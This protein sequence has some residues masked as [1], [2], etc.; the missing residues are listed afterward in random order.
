MYR[1]CKRIFDLLSSAL[2]LPLL[3]PLL[4]LTALAAALGGL[5]P[6]LF[7][8][9]RTG[10]RGQPFQLLKFR[11]MNQRRTAS[12]QLLP[13]EQRLTKLGKMLRATSLDELPQ[14]WNVLRGE[15]SLVGPR[16]FIH[17]YWPLYSAEQKRRFAVRPGLTGWAQVNGRNALSWEQK[18]AFDVWYVDN[19]SFGLDLRILVCTVARVLGARGVAAPGQ[20]TATAFTG[21][22][23]A[24]PASPNS[25]LTR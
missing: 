8:Q 22:P 13:D 19:L 24:A 3:L 17:E 11:T 15:L 10:Y 5:R 12:G 20:A 18:F 4:L 14:L 21:T 9:Q 2:L 1:H 16:P 25:P 23:P 6:V 7:W